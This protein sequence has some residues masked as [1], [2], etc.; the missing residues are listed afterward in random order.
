M[1]KINGQVTSELKD[2]SKPSGILAI[3]LHRGPDMKVEFRNIRL[4]EAKATK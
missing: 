4:K 2:T 3:Q 1:I